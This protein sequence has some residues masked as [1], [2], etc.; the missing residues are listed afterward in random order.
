VIAFRVEVLDDHGEWRG[1]V[2]PPAHALGIL[3]EE[4]E[5]A[6]EQWL[7]HSDTLP[8]DPEIDEGGEA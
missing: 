5:V 1:L 8:P 7:S 3:P 4:A 6:L 2:R